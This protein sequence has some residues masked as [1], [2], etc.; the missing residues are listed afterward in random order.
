[1]HKKDIIKKLYREG[2]LEDHQFKEILLDLNE[3]ETA[4]L[5]SFSD[6]RR[7]EIY[8]NK[9]YIRALIEF[10]NYCKNSC[11]YCG[12]QKENHNIKRYRLNKDII[13]M[14][15]EKAYKLGF[16]TFV[17][18]GGED[19]YFSDEKIISIIKNIKS[20]FP[21]AAITLSIGE[22][23]ESSYKAYFNA[24][25]DRY[26][27]R[28]ETSDLDHYRI[29]HPDSQKME[30]RQKCLLSLKKIGY[31]TGGG[32]M[33]SSPGQD[34][35]CIIK[36]L[37]FLKVLNPEMIG[38]GPF[39]PHKDTVFKNEAAG[40]LDLSLKMI[41]ILRLMFPNALIPATTALGSIREDGRALGI[42]AGANVI[43]PNIS[44]RNL[45]KLYSLYDGKIIEGD[46]D[47]LNIE[48]LKEKM[49]SIGYEIVI[50]RGDC[51]KC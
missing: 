25:A 10:T 42:K 45:R 49:K 14:L 28:E 50:D 33:I 43:M 4:L 38:V 1:M 2:N 32:F 12:L 17:L 18:Q 41:A 37:R 31:E 47:A 26:L 46:E 6:K 3:E 5:Y 23:D 40:E 19:P 39:I 22:K 15:C 34:I 7:K 8:G 16:R 24:G 21:D 27:L 11:R 29:L 20:R 35:D 36:D 44:P 30:D 48:S 9:I 13:Y 51:R